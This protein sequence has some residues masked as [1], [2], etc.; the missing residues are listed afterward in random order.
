MLHGDE[1]LVFI[2]SDD[3]CEVQVSGKGVLPIHATLAIEGDNVFIEPAEPNAI[4]RICQLHALEP[5]PGLTRLENGWIV[6]LG[7]TGE[8]AINI[9]QFF[10][11]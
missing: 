7:E 5:I 6:L 8:C 3:I 2:G 4:I 10:Q 11:G 9:S 1:C